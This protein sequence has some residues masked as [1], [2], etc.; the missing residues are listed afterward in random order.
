MKRK[1]KE[2]GEV[3]E[4]E[5]CLVSVARELLSKQKSLK[6][7]ITCGDARKAKKVIKHWV[8]LSAMQRDLH[9]ACEK[10]LLETFQ[11]ADIKL[12]PLPPNNG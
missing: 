9:L 5:P 8:T 6:D 11:L 10:N 4:D 12:P 3:E 1:Q 7:F 2:V